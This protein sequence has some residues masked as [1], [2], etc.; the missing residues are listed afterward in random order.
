MFASIL[1]PVKLTQSDQAHRSIEVASKLA[2]DCNAWLTLA[3]ITPHWVTVKDADYSWEARRW[4]EARAA[5]GLERL[6]AQ[7]QYQQCRTLSR[8]GSV[9]G[10][11]LDIAEEIGADLIVLPA[12]EPSLTDLFHR[13]DALRIAAK[14][15]CS[16]LLVR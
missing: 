9:P 12:A 5:A 15:C 13:P 4:L 14:T 6:K 10:S 16:A 1:V 3:T 7:A 2:R 11:I 8:W